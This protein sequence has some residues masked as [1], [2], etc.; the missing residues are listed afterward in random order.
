MIYNLAILAISFVVRKQIYISLCRKTLYGCLKV[1]AALTTSG[2]IVC[3][4][5]ASRSNAAAATTVAATVAAASDPAHSCVRYMRGWRFC[6]YCCY[7]CL[8]ILRGS[9]SNSICGLS[10]WRSSVNRNISELVIY[11]FR[12][13]L[14]L[15]FCR[16]QVNR[17]Q[18]DVSS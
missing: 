14:E 1:C 6:C 5:G 2:Q 17:K 16:A 4:A 18:R 12:Q 15:V 10:T 7:C 8:G 9:S 13:L 3:K 11:D